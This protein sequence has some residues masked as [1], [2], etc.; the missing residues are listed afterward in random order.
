LGLVAFFPQ[1]AKGPSPP[2][3]PHSFRR[4]PAQQGD[5]HPSTVNTPLLLFF[6]FAFRGSPFPPTQSCEGR[7]YWNAP[8]RF[9]FLMKEVFFLRSEN[10]LIRSRLRTTPQCDSGRLGPKPLVSIYFSFF[11]KELQTLVGRFFFRLVCS[12][13]FPLS[14][15]LRSPPPAPPSNTKSI[16]SPFP[17]KTIVFYTAGSSRT[18][19][20]FWGFLPFREAQV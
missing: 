18:G 14:Y 16:T 19:N 12:F 11:L 2:S 6:F 17:R 8:I 10:Q 13:F 4:C 20:S 15:L 7:V 9:F 5:P 3:F 1:G